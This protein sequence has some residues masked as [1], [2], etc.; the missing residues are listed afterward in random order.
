MRKVRT[1]NEYGTVETTGGVSLWTVPQKITTHL[2]LSRP[3]GLAGSGGQAHVANMQKGLAIETVNTTSLLRCFEVQRPE[4]LDGHRRERVKMCGKSTRVVFVRI[5][6]GKPYQ[7]QGRA[8]CTMI[9]FARGR[10]D[11]SREKSMRVCRIEK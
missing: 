1:H 4:G 11:S 7:E 2:R 8:A 9:R 5:L 6:W 10:R 3:T